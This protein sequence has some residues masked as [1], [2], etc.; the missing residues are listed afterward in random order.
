MVKYSYDA[1]WKAFIFS[2]IIFIFG[3]NMGSFIE[4]S[5]LDK[6]EKNVINSEVEL[7]DS[8]IRSNVLE[9]YNISCEKAIEN[10]FEI[11]DKIYEEVKMLEEL[12]KSST[13]VEGF[14]E[15]HKR[16]D[17]LRTQ[18]WLDAT[19][20]KTNCQDN[21]NL[22]V[23]IYEYNSKKPQVISIQNLYEELTSE[24]K[25]NYESEV[26][27]IPIANNMEL[28]SLELLLEN[29][30]IVN[31]TSIIINNKYVIKGVTNYQEIASYLN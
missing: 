20:L 11:A 14:D 17:L 15:V 1:F 25:S 21:F 16:Y 24:I 10:T 12:D 18:L 27:L 19:N 2:T 23:Y 8:N 4:N 7:Y 31:Q 29:Y 5:T 26:L 3:L 6:L 28:N 30:D 9:Y 22:I 13:I